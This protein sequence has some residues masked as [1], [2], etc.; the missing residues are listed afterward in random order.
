MSCSPTS[1]CDFAG[2]YDLSKLPEIKKLEQAALGCDYGGTSWTTRSQVDA[3][4]SSL[5]LDSSSQ[6]LDIGAGAGWPG[7][8]LGKL[9]QCDVTLLDIPLN[10]LT[11]AVQRASQDGMTDNVSVISASGLAIPFNDKSF[12][13]ISH[14]DVLCCL[15]E[16]L[17][18]LQESR[19]VARDGAR[20]NF[21]V[22]LPTENI[23][24]SEYE[25]VVITGPP[26]IGLDGCYADLLAEAGWQMTECDDVTIEYRDSLQR[27]VN[28]THDHEDELASL[29]GADELVGK[30]THREDQI[31]L[32]D[33]GLMRREVYVATT[34]DQ[35]TRSR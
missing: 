23:S 7:L 22:I 8:L 10:A 31:S 20:T 33:R 24:S 21:S 4:V 9:S 28:S 14:S 12:D 2:S 34:M 27:L 13:C 35:E 1:C 3:I 5:Q 32:I 30:R 25:E 11:Q 29:L 6:L 18:L 19:R 17:E 26:F 15:P 16:K